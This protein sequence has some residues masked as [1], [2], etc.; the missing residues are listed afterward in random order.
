M[1]K[2]RATGTTGGA[3]G[4]LVVGTG[5]TTAAPLTVGTDG[6]V[7]TAA[8][9][10]TTGLQW[11][12]PAAGSIT[13]IATGSMAGGNPVSITSIPQT[14]KQLQLYLSNWYDNNSTQTQIWFNNNTG[15]VYGWSGAK[16][17]NT[18]AQAGY[19]NGG[20]LLQNVYFT[21]SGSQTL[22]MNFWNYTST[23]QYKV[24]NFSSSSYQGNGSTGATVAG[25]WTGATTS[26][27]SSIQ[28][29]TQDDAW[30]AGTYT[31]YGVN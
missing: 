9:G 7:L 30:V 19:N 20:L 12:T 2:A 6:Q 4:A 22:A 16:A 28:I 23:S 10:Q 26:A 5:S 18:Q 13:Q 29:G 24:G 3:K 31:L 14:Y 27:I 25:G 1:T 17:G 8:S 15:G 11:A 21:T